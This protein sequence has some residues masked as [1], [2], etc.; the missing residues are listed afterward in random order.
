MNA[1]ALIPARYGSKRSPLKNIRE[2]GGHPLLAYS[3]F[4]AKKSG[5]FKKVILST[6]SDEIAKI[7]LKYGAEVPFMRPSEFAQDASTDFEWIDF[8]LKEL[9]KRGEAYDCFSILRPT[10]PFRTAETI[11]RAWKTFEES[12]DS[13][14]SIRAVQLCKEHPAKMWVMDEASKMMKPLLSLKDESPIPFHSRPYQ[15]L[16]KTYIQN[17]SL[18]IAWSRVIFEDRTISGSKVKAFLTQ[19]YEG[20]D[21][22]TEFDW[23]YIAHLLQ[24]KKVSLPELIGG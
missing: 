22:N 17:A 3:I 14:D 10:N 24:E 18:E 13:I 16:P 4:H 6:D 8:I 12:K 1:V 5:V 7:G 15:S 2:L 20:V 11:K 23:Y 9:K 21:I 19:E